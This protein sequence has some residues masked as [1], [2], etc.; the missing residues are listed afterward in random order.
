M[1][2]Y[3][4]A[5]LQFHAA[6]ILWGFTAILGALITLPAI[7]LVWWRVALSFVVLGT[8]IFLR[9]S[10]NPSFA[11]TMKFL[12]IGGVVGLHWLCFYGSIKLAN[13]SIALITMSTSAL[14]TMLIEA[15][16]GWKKAGRRDYFFGLGV[17]PAMVIVVGGMPTEMNVGFVVGLMSS[18]LLAIFTVLNKK[19]IESSDPWWITMIEMAGAWCAMSI[20][21]IVLWT[22]GSG[23]EWLPDLRDWWLLGILAVGCTVLP[24][25][26]SL[27]A[28][29]K[30]TAVTTNII[31][32]LEPVYGIIMAAVIL[33][34][35]HQFSP[36]FY[37]GAFCMLILVLAYP[38]F[39][40]GR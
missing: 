36:V 22:V 10:A 19:N 14:F 37:L 20:G 13:A 11:T 18:F 2:P 25:V 32:N 1:D 39:G 38:R 5:L 35:H 9:R 28:L 31:F 30:L 16:L 15:A 29:K 24:F 27:Y 3:N 21:M 34:D 7:A 17:I 26:L 6:V 4:K 40:K 23:V 12:G 33:G 8:L